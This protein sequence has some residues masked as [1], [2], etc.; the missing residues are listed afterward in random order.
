MIRK[1]VQFFTNGA[2]NSI[3]NIPYNNKTDKNE[4]QKLAGTIDLK[5]NTVIERLS[6]Y[7]EDK[8]EAS[9]KQQPFLVA[10]FKKEPAAPSAKLPVS[11]M[12]P[13]PEQPFAKRIAAQAHEK[14]G[15][16]GTST[17]TGKLHTP[18]KGTFSDN[19]KRSPTHGMP[20]LPVGNGP[21]KILS[22]VIKPAAK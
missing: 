13:P 15:T 1:M 4:V 22:G 12:P 20:P 2:M 16:A 7:C 19:I 9:A 3:L 18:V 21:V 5:L 6:D 17:A 8:L 10:K 11:V 14:S